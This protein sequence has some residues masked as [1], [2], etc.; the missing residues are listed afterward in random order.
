MWRTEFVGDLLC[1]P[2]NKIWNSLNFISL[3][4]CRVLSFSEFG[5]TPGYLSDP[6]N[7]LLFPSF[8]FY[9][10]PL[11]DPFGVCSTPLFYLAHYTGF[12]FFPERLS[13][14][15]VPMV[16]ELGIAIRDRIKEFTYLL[17]FWFEVVVTRPGYEQFLYF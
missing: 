3:L 14:T 2:R 12:P 10:G 13:V 1:S 9:S 15:M 6:P 4:L 16:V 8:Y 7:P 11:S 17:S 5:L